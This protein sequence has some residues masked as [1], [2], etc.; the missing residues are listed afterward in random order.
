MSIVDT[1]AGPGLASTFS[2]RMLAQREHTRT[3]HGATARQREFAL[4]SPTFRQRRT[5]F[6][7]LPCSDRLYWPMGDDGHDSD[8][9]AENDESRPD[10]VSKGSSA[11]HLL[12]R[13]DNAEPRHPDNVHQ[14]DSEHYKHHRPAAAEAVG[15]LLQPKPKNP[16]RR[17]RHIGKK[18][19]KRLL[20]PR[21]ACVLE[22]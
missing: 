12:G 17:G 20:T 9:D 15:D 11:E 8:P 10:R 5:P 2:R 3:K 6:L 18:E 19:R 4:E 7:I 22:R 21:Q 14:A 13:H 1:N 16:C